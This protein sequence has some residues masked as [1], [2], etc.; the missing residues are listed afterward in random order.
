MQEEL[1]M[2]GHWYA[3]R[4]K[5]HREF[6]VQEFLHSRGIETYLPL[7]REETRRSDASGRDKPFFSCYLF[8]QMDLTR[9]ALSSVNWSPGVNRVVSF[10]GQPAV[11]PTQV[12]Q[13]LQERLADIDTRG[14]YRGLPLNSGDCMR[15]TRGPLKGLEAI[16]DRRLSSGD[17]AQVFVEILG[18]L[19][20]C[21]ME[22]R[23]LE[24]IGS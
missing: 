3:V 18:R 24:R 4:T 5:P 8:A 11:V 22:L 19:T 12:L 1:A 14:Y 20:A 7:L 16:F 13:W 15:V 17:R 10:G 23:D 6:T 9:V 2:A 21:Q